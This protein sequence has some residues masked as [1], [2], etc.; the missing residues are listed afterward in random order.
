MKNTILNGILCIHNLPIE[1][2]WTTNDNVLFL[3]NLKLPLAL[4]VKNLANNNKI[5]FNYFVSDQKISEN[6]AIEN[7]IVTTMGFIDATIESEG[8]SYSE[9]TPDLCWSHDN[10][11][12]I[13][14]HDMNKR[15]S[16]FIGKWL[17]IR[18]SKVT[19]P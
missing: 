15:L 14:G 5:A 18:I 8:T 2:Q 13:G 10:K 11:F 3:H 19:A 7:L 4:H 12:I 6:E 9:V 17:L 1:D 16:K